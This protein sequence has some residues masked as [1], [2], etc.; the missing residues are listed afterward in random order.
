MLGVECAGAAV[1]SDVRPLDQGGYVVI[2]ADLDP[3]VVR[4]QRIIIRTTAPNSET[5][6]VPVR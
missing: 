2:L 1:K 6:M 4:D 3:E 5:I